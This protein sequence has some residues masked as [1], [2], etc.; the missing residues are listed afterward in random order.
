MRGV[1]LALGGG[2]VRGYAHLGVLR[3][4]EEAGIPIR[5]LAGSSAGALAAAAWAFGHKDPWKVH[6]AVFDREV[7][8]LRRTGN[9][10][11]L[12][13]LFAALRRP[14]LAEAARVAEGLKRLF[15]EA[16]L[17]ASPI[18]LAI[19]AADLLTGEAVVLREGPVWQAVLASAAIPGLFPPVPWEGRLLVDGDVAEKVPVRAAKALFPKV[20]AVDV[21]NPPP[22]EA[23]KTALEAALLAGEASRRRLKA[24]ALREADLVLP[25]EPP[26][27]IDTFDHRHLPLVYELGQ[28]RARERLG[29]IQAL[30]RVRLK[31]LAWALRR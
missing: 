21:S 12:A 29:E 25:L 10:R 6:E 26:F 7:A 16:R 17:E 3:V 1:A 24:L 2:G 30:A 23:P 28:K 8:E 14:A 11:T 5:G 9:L 19:Q 15:G 4:L 27:P 22:Q 18:P 31:D 20:V 13:R